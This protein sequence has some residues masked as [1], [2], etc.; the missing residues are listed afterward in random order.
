MRGTESQENLV[1]D[2]EY[3][4]QT[5]ASLESLQEFSLTPIEKKFLMFVER[6]DCATIRR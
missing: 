4:L 6:G 1:Q 2:T 3:V 5:E